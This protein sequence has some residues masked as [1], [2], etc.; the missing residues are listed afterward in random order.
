MAVRMS[1]TT[2]DDIAGERLKNQRLTRGGRRSPADVVSWLGAVQ[3]QE[4]AAASWALGLRMHDGVTLD[5]IERAFADGRILRTHV[6]RPTWHFVAPADIR[7][8][9][10]LTAP[11]VH[12]IMAPYNR[13]LG[14]DVAMLTRGTRVIERAL[15]DGR[16]LTRAELGSALQAAGL[17]LDHIRL[18]HTAM[19]AELEG[20]ICSG[21]R[22]AGKFTYAL[23][24]ERAPTAVRLS[25][26]DAVAELTRRFFRSHGPATAR[27]FAWWSGLTTADALR[28]LDMNR[29]RARTVEGRRYWTVGRLGGGPTRAAAAH[30]L[31]VY[32]EYLVAYRDREAV[33]HG[34][35]TMAFGSAR[36]VMFQHAF[37]IA[38]QIAGTWR[39]ARDARTPTI[40]I[41]PIRRLAAPE[42]R[43]VAE[44]AARYARFVG[45]PHTLSML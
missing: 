23:V 37:V 7:W 38:G 36:N 26:D 13:Q 10:E 44:A 39:P 41:A 8:L 2:F 9:L 24:A 27:D 6:M 5:A 19:H 31:P 12:R 4:Y 40:Q 22:R 16:H 20:V 25:R 45:V 29:A 1:Q 21:P 3:A 28:G 43:A 34:P 15:G 42:R 32:D 14:L 18:A 33:P 17:T 35:V 30:L 11:R